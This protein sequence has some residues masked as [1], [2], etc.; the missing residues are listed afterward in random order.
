[1]PDKGVTLDA[2]RTVILLALAAGASRQAAAGKAGISERTLYRWVAAEP[3]FAA[4]VEI[5][6]GTGR[7]VYE[8]LLLEAAKKDWRAAAWMLEV[9]FVGRS[10]SAP[11][12][13]LP[14]AGQM[15][16]AGG[17]ALSPEQQKQ[18]LD[19][20]VATLGRD[21]AERVLAGRVAQVERDRA[22]GKL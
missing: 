5:A 12:E 15:T 10:K 11:P 19:M 14:D 7:A 20:L 3:E 22:D 21:G 2:K 4:A 1:M 13:E 18:M 16:V 6:L 9:L 17:T 8:E